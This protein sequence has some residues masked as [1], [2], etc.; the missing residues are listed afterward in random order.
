IIYL[1]FLVF[2]I[3]SLIFSKGN[4]LNKIKK[5]YYEFLIGLFGFGLMFLSPE[6]PI[7]ARFGALMFLFVFIINIIM[8]I[9]FKN[10]ILKKYFSKIVYS[11]MVALLLISY[12]SFFVHYKNFD[13]QVKERDK[14]LLTPEKEVIVPS[15]TTTTRKYMIL[16]EA[17]LNTKSSISNLMQNYYNKDKILVL[18]RYV[19]DNIYVKNNLY[20]AFY[21]LV[22]KNK[23]EFF[24]N[25][26]L[27]KTLSGEKFVFLIETQ[28]NSDLSKILNI[29]VEHFSDRPSKVDFKKISK[30]EFV[31]IRNKKYFPVELNRRMSKITK[32]KI[33]IETI[34]DKNEVIEFLSWE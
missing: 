18:D 7:R 2:S 34:E 30:E 20:N 9:E 25:F 5:Y 3:Y 28:H 10:I 24:K 29:V 17:G 6:F 14:I 19:Y 12:K 11:T 27:S 8:E 4:F 15:Y 23:N 26:Y 16:P 1:F 22:P 21:H 32:I 33:H 13:L 31:I